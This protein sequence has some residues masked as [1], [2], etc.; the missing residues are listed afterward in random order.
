MSDIIDNREEF[1]AEH[2]CRI[3]Q[4]SESVKFAVGYFFVSGLKEIRDQ[5]DTLSKIRLLIGNQSNQETVDALMQKEMSPSRVQSAIGRLQNKKDKERI[6]EGT[7]KGVREILSI[8][9]LTDETESLLRQ[10]KRLLSEEKLEVRVYTKEK[11]HAKAYL[12]G[13][14]EAERALVLQGGGLAQEPAPMLSAETD[15]TDL[16][17]EG[18]RV[19]TGESQVP[20]SAAVEEGTVVHSKVAR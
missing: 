6:V 18:L 4:Q 7:G 5:L 3:L 8:P 12:F 13:L 10:I 9:P 11:L 1:L 2:V 17:L 20:G 14:T 16:Q 15:R 19:G